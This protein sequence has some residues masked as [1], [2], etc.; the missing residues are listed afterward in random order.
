MVSDVKRRASFSEGDSF[1]SSCNFL[2]GAIVMLAMAYKWANYLA[3][4]H[5][6]QF[7]FVN[8]RVS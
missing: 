8:I 4:L 6:N 3:Q 5:D 1:L 2:V 7:W